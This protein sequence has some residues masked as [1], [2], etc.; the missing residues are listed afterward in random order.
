[1][2]V[3]DQMAAQPT[4]TVNGYSNVPVT[5]ITVTSASQTL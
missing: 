2:T 4:T 5:D 1:M 3:I